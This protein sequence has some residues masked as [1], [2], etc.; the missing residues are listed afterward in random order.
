MAVGGI[1]QRG[2]PDRGWPDRG[3]PLAPGGA[4]GT[5]GNERARRYLFTTTII[6][7]LLGGELWQ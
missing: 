7:Y 3:I 5:S 4:G 2:L 1:P 6:M